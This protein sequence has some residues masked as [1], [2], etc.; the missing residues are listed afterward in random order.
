MTA[1]ICLRN[2]VKSYRSGTNPEVP[3]LH[4]LNLEVPQR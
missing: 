2:V 3:V 1:A 4:G